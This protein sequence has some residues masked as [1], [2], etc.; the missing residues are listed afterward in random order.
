MTISVN[1]HFYPGYSVE[2]WSTTAPCN[3]TRMTC[4]ETENQTLMKTLGQDMLEATVY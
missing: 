4:R 2:K 1:H 3:Q